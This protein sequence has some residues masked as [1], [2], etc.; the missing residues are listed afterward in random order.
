MVNILLHMLWLLLQVVK[1]GFVRK[2]IEQGKTCNDLQLKKEE[3]FYYFIPIGTFF[4]N[5]ISAPL[6]HL[7]LFLKISRL[8][9]KR[10]QG[11][12]LIN[13]WRFNIWR[14]SWN[15]DH[16]TRWNPHELTKISE[17]SLLHYPSLE[18]TIN[19]DVD[20][21]EG[22]RAW[23]CALNLVTF[24]NLVTITFSWCALS[25]KGFWEETRLRISNLISLVGWESEIYFRWIM[26][27]ASG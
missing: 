25:M 9:N 24:S 26:W 6:K 23:G 19:D 27:S 16:F 20:D 7:F 17:A 8:M 18:F 3:I 10:H 4:I 2:K 21:L 13:M 1:M 22:G 11:S 15:W 5:E 14:L 12:R